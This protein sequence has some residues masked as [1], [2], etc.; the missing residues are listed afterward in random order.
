MKCNT[1]GC[2]FFIIER[3]N[4]T[5]IAPVFYIYDPCLNTGSTDKVK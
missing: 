3:D 5:G 4:G 2:F 1:G